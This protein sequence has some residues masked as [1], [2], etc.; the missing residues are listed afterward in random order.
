MTNMAI[1]H[2]RPKPK[3]TFDALNNFVQLSCGLPVGR[4]IF[5]AEP[6]QMEHLIWR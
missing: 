4:V 3:A 2:V 6:D 5:R 1:D